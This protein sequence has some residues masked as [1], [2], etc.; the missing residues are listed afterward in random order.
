MYHIRTVTALTG[1]PAVT[2]RAWENRYGV[3]VPSRTDG[4]HRVY[5]EQ[6]VDDLRWLKGQ[7]E[8]KGINISQA[9]QI[10]KLK[11]L[12]QS[13]EKASHSDETISNKVS[14]FPEKSVTSVHDD[15]ALVR[16]IGFSS[17][18]VSFEKW[19]SELYDVLTSFQN[20]RAHSLT[21]AAFARHG[22]DDVF[23]H[24][25]APLLHRIGNE[26]E[27]GTLTM[28]Q[29]HFASTFVMHRFNHFFQSL[30]VISS[31]PK[32]LAFCPTGEHHQIGLLMFTLF[33][34]KKGA[35]VIYLGPNTTEDGLSGL[36]EANG[37][38]HVCISLTDI[39]FLQTSEQTI[40]RLLAKHSGLQ[41]LLGGQAFQQVGQKLKKYRIGDRLA[42]WENWFAHQFR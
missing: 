20:D 41:F 17:E 35:D 39:R 32:W 22:E 1:I 3:I 12:E 33:L 13:S 14:V 36:I 2:I 30:P 8:N 7:V 29:E 23:H 19:I 28:A 4:G 21:E 18:D 42:D 6:D 26:W 9:S 37:I 24:I 27:N 40:E 38:R 25:F 5:S 16:S 34:R 31:L 11:K 15:D 10:L